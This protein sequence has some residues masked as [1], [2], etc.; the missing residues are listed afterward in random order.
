MTFVYPTA[1][2]CSE[3]WTFGQEEAR[4]VDTWWM[5]IMRRLRGVT[6]L[7]RMRSADILADLK[8]TLLSDLINMRQLRYLGHIQRYPDDR[9][10]KY[11]LTAERPGQVNTGKQKQWRKE[12]V[13]KLEHRGLDIDMMTKPEK[14][15]WRERLN[16]I[17]P[18]PA[19]NRSNNEISTPLGVAP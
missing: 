10:V 17:F 18:K 6:L 14:A 9:W 3:T 15:R 12:I 1:T 19:D 13:K 8:A 5:K 16:Q 2:C 7:E 4:I 11:A